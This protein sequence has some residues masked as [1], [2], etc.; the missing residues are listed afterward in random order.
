MTEA[1][2]IDRIRDRTARIS[3]IGQGYVGL[4]L[5]VEF[6]RAGFSVTG[7]DTD[8]DRVTALNSGRSY[9]PDVEGD[10]LT[11][12]LR[13]GRHEALRTLNH[14]PLSPGPPPL[15][16]GRAA[17]RIVDVLLDGGRAGGGRAGWTPAGATRTGH[18]S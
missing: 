10:D 15:W 18:H 9:S 7:L 11:A 13:T 16:D 5:A 6:A 2:L 8:L 3:V 4:P 1:K 12:L 14:P 17:E